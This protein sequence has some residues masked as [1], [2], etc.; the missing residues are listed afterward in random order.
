[1]TPAKLHFAAGFG[2]RSKNKKG[3]QDEDLSQCLF[4]E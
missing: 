1:V 2:G 4:E 3:L